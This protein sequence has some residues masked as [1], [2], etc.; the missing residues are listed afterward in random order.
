M[1]V[2]PIVLMTASGRQA[3]PV[4]DFRP[5]RPAYLVQCRPAQTALTSATVFSSVMDGMPAPAP[6]RTREYPPRPDRSAT[7]GSWPCRATSMRRHARH[8]RNSS[9]Y[10]ARAA[11]IAY[12]RG[13]L[14]EVHRRQ[15]LERREL[16]RLDRAAEPVH[17]Q[18]AQPPREASSNHGIVTAIPHRHRDLLLAIE[19]LRGRRTHH[20]RC[21]CVG[22]QLVAGLRV[23]GSESPVR[24]AGSTRIC[25]VMVE[26]HLQAG[27]QDLVPGKALVYGHN[28]TDGCID[29]AAPQPRG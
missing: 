28:I 25:G 3:T 2:V 6:A 18:S 17:I 16:R 23:M 19:L 8:P 26:S 11:D 29:L 15:R 20:C 1:A 5:A 7:G 21:G 27:R 14:A 22:P 10:T 13:D 4:F 24:A 9:P 12:R